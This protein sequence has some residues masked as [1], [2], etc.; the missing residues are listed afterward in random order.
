MLNLSD[1]EIGH[2][3]V[4]QPDGAVTHAT[5]SVDVPSVYHDPEHDIEI[6]GRGK[7]TALKGYTGQY[8]YNGAVMHNSEYMGGRLE[9]D[10]RATP[11][12]YVMVE[13][14]DLD[15]PDDMPEGWVVLR[16]DEGS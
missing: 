8:S 12:T 9:D 3:F 16:L 6:D 13:V 2:P 14:L 4:V 15:A 10:V 5:Q 7:W 1:I 11:G